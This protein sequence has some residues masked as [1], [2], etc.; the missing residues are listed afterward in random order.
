MSLRRT[1][2]RLLE[3]PEMFD[4][5]RRRAFEREL[6]HQAYH[7]ALTGLPNRPLV[8]DRLRK[9]LARGRRRGMSCGVLFLDLDRFKTVND[10]MAHLFGDRLLVEVAK[11]LDGCV[12][13]EDTV[14]RLGGDE[15]L[16]LLE[17]VDGRHDA[18]RAAT[19]IA[20]VLTPSFMVLDQ[21]IFVTTSIGCAISEP[22]HEADDLLRD[23][24]IA[25]YCAKES[26]P[27][28]FEV[29]EPYMSRRAI[30]RLELETALRHAVERH[31]LELLFQ[32]QVRLDSGRIVAAEALLRWRHPG[33]GWSRRTTSSRSPRN[34][35]R[36]C[37][38]A[39]GCSRR[40]V[41][42]PSRG[43]AG[44]PSA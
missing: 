19:R 22:D 35:A 28:A 20:D 42:R 1:F 11:R 24:D 18:V 26:G 38:S 43:R 33:A 5:E 44:P 25:L 4:D 34:P 2:S 9:A 36:S 32:P 12:R 39:A 29:F 17:D 13:P 41:T 27:G 6:E 16:V 7:D 21:E 8:L 30:D 40:R 3:S 37:R 10:S 23:A 15:F 31:E 14:A